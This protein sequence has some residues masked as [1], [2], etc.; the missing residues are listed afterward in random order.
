[1]GFLVEKQAQQDITHSPQ[2]RVVSSKALPVVPIAA[3]RLLQQIHYG[4]LRIVFPNGKTQTYGRQNSG[5]DCTWRIHNENLF[6][7]LIQQGSLGL[8]ESYMDGE[9][10][11][12]HG[13]LGDFFCILFQNKLWEHIRED[14][15]TRLRILLQHLL[16]SPT[17]LTS[18]SKNVRDHYDLGNAFFSYMLDRSMTYSCGYQRSP[19]ETLFEIQQ[20]KYSLIADKLAIR[21]SDASLVDVGCGWGG[22]LHYITQ[23]FANIHATG[24]TLSQKQYHYVKNVLGPKGMSNRAKALLL[25]YR[26]LDGTFDYFVSIGMFEHVGRQSYSQFMGMIRRVLRPGGRG[27]LHTISTASAPEEGS[28]PWLMKYIFPGGYLP[29][30]EEITYEMRRAGLIITHIENLREHYVH[31]IAHW[32]AN[33]NKHR[34]QVLKLGGQYS[35]RFMR[36]W[37]FYLYSVEASFRTGPCQLYQVLFQKEA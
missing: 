15:Q 22:M 21:D 3:H 1:V 35:E 25:D 37:E 33:F 26:E 9:W 32:R 31:T 20:N 2:L 12:L 19:D 29:R 5:Y 18:S 11:I 4:T 7:R 30:L 17:R 24:I 6:I 27:L 23:R 16:R 8:G 36:M 10:E 34:E 28:D 14:I 13:S